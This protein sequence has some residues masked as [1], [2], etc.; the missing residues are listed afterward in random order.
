MSE[1]DFGFALEEILAVVEGLRL[2]NEVHVVALLVA[3]DAEYLPQ[4]VL[5]TNGDGVVVGVGLLG[6]GG[7]GEAGVALEK[8]SPAKVLVNSLVVPVAVDELGEDAPETPDV[9][10]FVVNLLEEDDLGGAVPSCA[11]LLREPPLGGL[12]LVLEQVA[13]VED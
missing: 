8:D 1:V 11:D 10:R 5:V 6:D 12:L 13:L 2:G 3:H 7:E 9:D 4:L